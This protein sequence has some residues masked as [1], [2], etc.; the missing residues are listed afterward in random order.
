M[1][2]K[3][4]LDLVIIKFLKSFNNLINIKMLDI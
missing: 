4:S 3:K 1:I 2:N